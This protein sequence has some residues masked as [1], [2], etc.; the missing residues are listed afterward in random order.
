[1]QAFIERFGAK[2]KEVR[3]FV[4]TPLPLLLLLLWD[5]AADAA[6]RHRAT[7]DCLQCS[8]CSECWVNLISGRKPTIIVSILLTRC[9]RFCSNS[10]NFFATHVH[11]DYVVSPALLQVTKDAGDAHAL[12][13]FEEP[14][15]R[16][17]FMTEYKKA[18]QDTTNRGQ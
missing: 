10:L 16:T 9:V 8:R 4:S 6:M 15:H 3:G 12:V 2:P 17:L 13:V 14:N 11:S 5:F 7:V 1:M 18:E